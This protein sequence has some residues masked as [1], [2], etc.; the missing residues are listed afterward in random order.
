MQHVHWQ[1]VEH[2]SSS[3][4]PAATAA[5]RSS[6]PCTLLTYGTASQPASPSLLCTPPPAPCNSVFLAASSAGREPRQDLCNLPPFACNA[7][8]ELVRFI[9]PSAG[10]TCKRLPEAFANLTALRSLDLSGNQLADTTEH[11]ASVVSRMKDLRRLYLRTTGL[12]G[13]LGCEM[14]G[15]KLQVSGGGSACC[16]VACW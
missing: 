3:A 10:L 8:G 5:H 9:A 14:I 16:A 12:E 4:C 13:T 7:K 6:P 11:V 2:S 15:P 1:P